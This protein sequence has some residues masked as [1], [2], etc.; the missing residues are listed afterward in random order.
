MLNAESIKIAV[1]E[2]NA[3]LRDGL[4]IFLN[5]EPDLEV[6]GEF[7]TAAEAVAEVGGLDPD[8]I[9]VSSTLPDMTGY[10]A[11]IQTEGVSPRS[12]QIMLADGVNG[13]EIIAGMMAGC[14]GFLPKDGPK[15]DLLRTIRAIGRGEMLLI[16]PV[17]DR[18][19]RFLRYNRRY[20]DVGRLTSRERQVIVLAA[21]GL[22]NADI[23]AQLSLSQHTVRNCLSN[24]FSKLGI[25][26]RSELGA[27]ATLLGMLDD[28]DL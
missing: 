26:S 12:K 18:A 1:V 19:L 28:E 24:I 17:A 3:F 25:S 4:S 23:G 11:C 20:V 16:A 13:P 8:V 22:N 15:S 2:A 5:N 27:F 7:G 21:A 9:I 10:E 6:V 14:A